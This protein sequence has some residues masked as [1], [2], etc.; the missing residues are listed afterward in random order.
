MP[1]RVVNWM[2]VSLAL[3]LALL[4]LAPLATGSGP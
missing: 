1:P 3:V 4:L 2:I